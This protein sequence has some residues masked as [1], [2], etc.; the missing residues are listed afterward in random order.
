MSSEAQQ[1]MPVSMCVHARAFILSLNICGVTSLELEKLGTG[2]DHTKVAA[3]K[4]TAPRSLQGPQPQ[5]VLLHRCSH[6]DDY[7]HG[8]HC[9]PHLSPGPVVRHGH[10]WSHIGDSGL[11]RVDKP[12]VLEVLMR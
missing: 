5:L 4:E 1:D 12:A 11:C 2:T 10:S 8:G 6:T 9:A 3:L 7:P